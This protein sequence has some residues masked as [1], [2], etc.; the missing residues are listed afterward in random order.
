MSWKYAANFCW[1]F[2]VDDLSSQLNTPRGPRV[3]E[4]QSAYSQGSVGS[5]IPLHGP[6]L[7]TPN[8]KTRLKH[9]RS[10][11]STTGNKPKNGPFLDNGSI[12]NVFLQFGI[13]SLRRLRTPAA[14]KTKIQELWGAETWTEILRSTCAV[15]GRQRKAACRVAYFWDCKK[16]SFKW[17]KAESIESL[18]HPC[19]EE[20][21]FV[22]SDI[23][24]WGLRQNMTEGFKRLIQK[25]L[26]WCSMILES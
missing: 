21:R 11:R 10:E 12:W 9:G 19:S 7:R 15:T 5:L 6:G 3:I 1:K 23:P 4:F 20:V 2:F 17:L 13:W 14:G 25:P 24:A 16:F 18:R 8:T 26:Q 22:R